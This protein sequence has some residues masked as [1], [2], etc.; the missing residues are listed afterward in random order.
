VTTTVI[1]PEILSYLGLASEEDWQEL[2]AWGLPKEVSEETLEA[3]LQDR[4]HHPGLFLDAAH[5]A[6]FVGVEV[7]E[8]ERH[9]DL[10]APARFSRH[11]QPPFYW[12]HRL[13]ALYRQ[14]LPRRR[15]YTSIAQSH[16]HFADRT[17]VRLARCW[18]CGEE[19]V[20]FVCEACG[21]SVDG[22]HQ[23]M[24]RDG[25]PVQYEPMRVCYRCLSES[26]ERFDTYR[27]PQEVARWV[28]ENLVG[29]PA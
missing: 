24:V 2:R 21:H 6:A 26:P 18:V 27:S 25:R 9:A 5:A 29:E 22:R 10:F 4:L 19:A 28:A 20:L 23:E 15:F 1:K 14:H 11:T 17:G 8:L 3:W 16:R 13:R 7:E 12:R